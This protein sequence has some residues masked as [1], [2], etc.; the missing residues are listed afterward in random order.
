MIL[1]TRHGDRELRSIGGMFAGDSAIPMPA[2][3]V[4]LGAWSASGRRVTVESASG[5]PAILRGIRIISEAVASMPLLAIETDEEGDN[6]RAKETWQ[7]ELL[8]DS[9]NEQGTTPFTFKE[10]LTASMV[11]RGGGFALKAK[12]RG[13]VQA[14]YPLRPSRVR[15]KYKNEEL[16]FDVTSGKGQTKTLTAEDVLYIPG[17]LLDDPSI[18]VSPITVAANALGTGLGAEEYAGRFF[19]N[20]ATPAG[21]I[22]FTQSADSQ[23][24]KDSRD[25]WEDRHR[26]GRN[27]HK[28]AALFGGADYQ[29]IGVTA[30]DAQIIE[31]QKWTVEQCARV[32]GLPGWLLGAETGSRARVTPEEKNMEVMQFSINPW[33]KR[34][35]EGLHADPDL[36]PDKTLYPVF[37]ADHLVR[38]DMGMRY[39]AY[40]KARQGG[41]QS[42]ND[43]RRK[44]N[45][46]PIE[47]GDDYQATPVGGAPNLQPGQGE[48]GVPEDPTA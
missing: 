16:V 3:G 14:L 10:Y 38:A 20:D 21:V 48:T 40:L 29:S 22:K 25:T 1:A 28:V 44:E 45:E 42:V 27:A 2:I 46:P 4:G 41:W 6:R 9:P 15:P 43:I 39:E 19:D 17:L 32:L 7:R 35:E 8:H 26:G 13:R 30:R 12:A 24:A 37:D 18:G 33:L 11:A 5:L 47:G 36:F 34:F 23:A 31:T